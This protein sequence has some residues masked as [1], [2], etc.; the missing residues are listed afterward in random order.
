MRDMN[1]PTPYCHGCG[2]RFYNDSPLSDG[3]C[4]YCHEEDAEMIK[5][6]GQIPFGPLWT[7]FGKSNG[8]FYANKLDGPD[9]GS[10]IF[11][12]KKE[13]ADQ[14][15]ATIPDKSLYRV[16]KTHEGEGPTGIVSILKL[17]L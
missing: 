10:V 4:H 8:G 12:E 3:R 13:V 7:L 2:H 17:A 9:G 1:N 11:F 5:E 16:G 15:L 14:F 6:I